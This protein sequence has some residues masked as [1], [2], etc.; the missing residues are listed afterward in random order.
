LEQ[1]RVGV[2]GVG[3]GRVHA[4]HYRDCP[5]ADLVAVCDIDRGRLEHVG[6]ETGARKLYDGAEALLADQE[7]DAVS[8][9]VPNAYHAPL[10]LAALEA[11]KHVLCEKPLAMNAEEAARMVETARRLGRKLMVH[12]NFR[13]QPTS[14]AVKRALDAGALGHVYYARSVWHRRRGIPNLGGWFTRKETAG[15]GA[16]IDIGIH[17]LDLALWLMGYPRPVSVTGIVHDRLGRRL[18]EQEGKPFDVD[19]FAAAFIRFENGAALTLETSWASNSEKREDQST[20]LFGVDGG[21]VLRNWDEGYQYEARLFCPRD[22]DVAAEV[23]PAPEC[24]ET[25]QQHFCRSILNGTEPAG[26]GEEGLLVMRL[27]DAIYRSAAT[28]EEVRLA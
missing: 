4:I 10:T 7:I 22:G 23:P 16:L 19:D 24:L 12:F 15:G 5:E 25:P 17:R 20:Q 11:G 1:V 2:I 3:M 8:I 26:S 14:Q 6:W 18:A 27:L 21:A 9:A 13:F 28:G